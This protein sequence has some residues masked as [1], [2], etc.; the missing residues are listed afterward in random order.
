MQD[1]FGGGDEITDNLV[2][3]MVRES[4]VSRALELCSPRS[5]S[6]AVRSSCAAL[7]PAA[8]LN[9]VVSAA[10]AAATAALA[11]AKDHGPWNSWWADRNNRAAN[12]A[13]ESLLQWLP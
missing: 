1:G 10:A 7:G 9:R 12:A 5:R 13:C 6:A 8:E 3:N 2:L 4:K 11:V